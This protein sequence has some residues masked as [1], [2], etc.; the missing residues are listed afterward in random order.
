ME[1]V[2]DLTIEGAHSLGER[3]RE[4]ALGD[5]VEEA[6]NKLVDIVSV[7]GN[8]E[9]YTPNNLFI[10]GRRGSG[11]TTVL[12]TIK[13]ILSKVS[14]YEGI[15]EKLKELHFEIIDDV[16]D[17]SVNTMSITFYFLGWLKERIEKEFSCEKEL[18]EYLYEAI[19]YFPSY[20]KRCNGNCDEIKEEENLEERLDRSDLKFRKKLYKLID[21]YCK[22]LERKKTF[23]VLFLDDLDISFPLERLQRILTE[24]YMFLSHP[25]LIVVAAGNYSNLTDAVEKWIQVQRKETEE[26]NNDQKNSRKDVA[27]SFL[28][29]TF[30]VHSVHIPEISYELVRDYLKV[31]WQPGESSPEVSVKSFL[32]A[33][34][35]I[36]LLSLDSL[37]FRIL[38]NGLTMRELILILKEVKKK[39]ENYCE[40]RDGRFVFNDNLLKVRIIDLC[41]S[42]IY[43]KVKKVKVAISFEGRYYFK[44]DDLGKPSEVETL[45]LR[46][47]EAVE[48][49]KLPEF[50][51]DEGRQSTLPLILGIEGK[52]KV[53]ALFWVWFNENIFFMDGLMRNFPRLVLW[54]FLVKN[55]LR[56]KHTNKGRFIKQ[57]DNEKEILS[58]YNMWRSLN[59]DL[60]IF[61]DEYFELYEFLV[62]SE[63]ILRVN[64]PNIHRENVFSPLESEEMIIIKAGNEYLSLEK[65]LFSFAEIKLPICYVTLSLI[66]LSDTPVSLKFLEVEKTL[67]NFW[68][69]LM[70]ALREL[71]FPNPFISPSS[72]IAKLLAFE[73]IYLNLWYRLLYLPRIT[74]YGMPKK[75]FRSFVISKEEDLPKD[76]V[77][78]I[79]EELYNLKKILNCKG[80]R[81]KIREVKRRFEEIL[82]E[83]G[84]K[85]IRE[86]F[87]FVWRE[88]EEEDISETAYICGERKKEIKE[89]IRNSLLIFLSNLETWIGE[90]FRD[91][92]VQRFPFWIA[93][94]PILKILREELSGEERVSWMIYREAFKAPLIRAVLYDGLDNPDE[95]LKKLFKDK[96]K[97]VKDGIEKDLEILRKRSGLKEEGGGDQEASS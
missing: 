17:T 82:D 63:E 75:F 79:R 94:S 68:D 26:N 40:F 25:K 87:Q 80:E 8:S 7:R 14:E 54:E 6:L 78:L 38:F 89:R 71:K 73:L 51:Y 10:D 2:I 92:V 32:E 31:K 15:P 13:E 5:V 49:G 16:L 20:L 64:L 58:F 91:Q 56:N 57:K 50:L 1:R 42:D 77:L 67:A 3:W 29:K 19:K 41:F 53:G 88:I 81:L 72:G 9:G 36:R 37:P 22:V 85:R 97:E 93:P 44:A 12:L 96:W 76:R 27:K 30:A 18:L 62:G 47:K 55:I 95:Y 59:F 34:P 65:I 4:R 90:K 61:A 83:I 24:I 74:E 48:K 84:D 39:I 86:I 45:M 43:Q 66:Y 11:K 52:K 70:E 33:L 23:I 69:K 46:L 21:E 28:E 60:D 35:I